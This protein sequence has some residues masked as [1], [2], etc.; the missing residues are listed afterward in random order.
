MISSP[1]NQQNTD[2]PSTPPSAL[3]EIDYHHSPGNLLPRSPG[4]YDFSLIINGTPSSKKNSDNKPTTKRRLTLKRSKSKKDMKK[5]RQAVEDGGKLVPSAPKNDLLPPLDISPIPPLPTPTSASASTMTTLQ[6]RPRPIKSTTLEPTFHHALKGAHRRSRSF[7]EL[8]TSSTPL[9]FRPDPSSLSSSFAQDDSTPCPPHQPWR[10]REAWL[11]IHSSTSS[12][13]LQ[14]K[15]T[16]VGHL[17]LPSAMGDVGGWRG[18]GGGAFFGADMN[19]PLPGS[20]RVKSKARRSSAGGVDDAQT[21]APLTPPRGALRPSGIDRSTVSGTGEHMVAHDRH[22][23]KLNR[24]RSD[25]EDSTSLTSSSERLVPLAKHWNIPIVAHP[26]TSIPMRPAH[27]EESSS[28]SSSN[29][30]STSSSELLLPPLLPPTTIKEISFTTSSSR[31]TT[32]IPWGRSSSPGAGVSVGIKTP[33]CTPSR[34]YSSPLCQ[35][36]TPTP[37]STPGFT[38][39]SIFR[40]NTN[41]GSSGDGQSTPRTWLQINATPPPTLSKS[42]GSRGRSP[43]TPGVPETPST[44]TQTRSRTTTPGSIRLSKIK[45]CTSPTPDRT[46]SKNEDDGRANMADSPSGTPATPT[47]R[48]LLWKVSPIVWGS[49]KKRKG[50]IKWALED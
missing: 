29:R 50:S 12:K 24:N 28:S 4:S 35:Q 49:D 21:S 40:R 47:G 3:S 6:S 48:R 14:E 5:E 30:S 2:R 25:S 36:Q 32:P 17:L 19:V 31:E 8:I 20:T 43:N 7:S 16:Q 1:D 39:R 41:T 13:Q 33:P 26:D 45:R 44:P 37:T 10:S 34:S 38:P 27:E 11:A 9:F 46:R 15:E 22:A 18:R 42:K 23:V